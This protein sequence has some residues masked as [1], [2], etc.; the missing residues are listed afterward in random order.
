M[1]LHGR[2]IMVA[3]KNVWICQWGT[4]QEL[5]PKQKHSWVRE[6]NW[7]QGLLGEDGDSPWG[8]SGAGLS[9]QSPSYLPSQ[10]QDSQGRGIGA[11]LGMVMGWGWAR[12]GPA[13]A[14]WDWVQ[15]RKWETDMAA[16]K[17]SRGMGATFQTASRKGA[18][19]LVSSSSFSA[20]QRCRGVLRTSPE[21]DSLNSC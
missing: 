20:E 11:S 2:M 12:T 8:T 3:R 15:W 1:I 10:E 7:G 16:G 18:Q 21:K 14:D 6:D 17:W 9:S 13:S 5:E 4:R 19:A